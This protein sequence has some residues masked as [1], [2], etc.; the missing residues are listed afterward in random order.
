[1][2]FRR[3]KYPLH[4]LQIIVGKRKSFL[5]GAKPTRCFFDTVKSGKEL[6][7]ATEVLPDNQTK[8]RATGYS[9]NFG[10]R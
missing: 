3:T 2:V 1:M 6:A 7:M 5:P 8:W 9:E 4:G 10:Q